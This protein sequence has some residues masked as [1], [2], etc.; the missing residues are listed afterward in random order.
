MNAQIVMQKIKGKTLC[1]LIARY[2]PN[3]GMNSVVIRTD[4]ATL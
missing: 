2:S 3:N 4:D 1:M